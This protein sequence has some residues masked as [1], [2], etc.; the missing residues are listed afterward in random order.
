MKHPEAKEQTALI[1]W[2]AFD[3]S[4]YPELKW[5]Y[6]I[7]NDLRVTPQRARRAKAMGMKAG[8][9]DLCFPVPRGAYHGFYIEMKSAKGVLS[10]AQR[11]FLQF[12]KSVG[13]KT[14][15]CRSAAEAREKILDYLSN[16]G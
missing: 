10:S 3:T 12:V 16:D 13:Y 14:A 8:I 11:D 1:Q 7:P 2:L 9:S 5:L 6:A 4:K 15:V